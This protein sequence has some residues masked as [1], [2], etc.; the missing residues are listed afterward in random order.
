LDEYMY[1]IISIGTTQEE[2][3]QFL[4]RQE[5]IDCLFGGEF[6]ICPV[7]QIAPPGMLS[8]YSVSLLASKPTKSYCSLQVIDRRM[9]MNLDRESELS[10]FSDNKAVYYPRWSRGGG[11]VETPATGHVARVAGDIR[12]CTQAFVGSCV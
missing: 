5:H 4:G 7:H 12:I 10:L 2:N 9:W 8:R 6:Y 1:F 3:T 11:C